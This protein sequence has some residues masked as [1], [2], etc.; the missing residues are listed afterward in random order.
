MIYLFYDSSLGICD[1]TLTSTTNVGPPSGIGD[2]GRVARVPLDDF[3]H[4][5]SPAACC[6]NQSPDRSSEYSGSRRSLP[7]RRRP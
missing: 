7:G 2:A 5:T 6:A 3:F 4:E 1:S